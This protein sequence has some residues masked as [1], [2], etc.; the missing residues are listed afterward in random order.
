VIELDKPYR[1]REIDL[2]LPDDGKHFYNYVVETSL[3]GKNFSVLPDCSKKACSGPQQ[4]TFP[5][6]KI[7]AIKIKGLLNSQGK[8]FDALAIEAYCIPPGAAIK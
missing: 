2:L 7:G 6:R 1:L 5:P 3:D 4:I 8:Q